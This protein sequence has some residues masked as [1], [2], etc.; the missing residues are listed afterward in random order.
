MITKKLALAVGAVI[1]LTACSDKASETKLQYP[2]TK[3]GEVVDSYFETKVADPYRW[4]EDDMSAETAAWVESQNQ[5]TQGYLEQIPYREQIEQRLTKL[6]DYK[7]EG[8]PFVEGDYRYYYKNDGL[9]NQSVLYRQRGDEAEEIFLDPNSFSEDGTVSLAGITFSED[10]SLAAYQISEGGSDWRKVYVIDTNTKQKLEA[11]LVD[12]KFSNISWRGNTGFYYSSYDKPKGSELSAKTD[13]HKLYFHKLGT[14]QNQDELVFGG[15]DSEKHRYVGSSVTKDEKYLFIYASVST[16][17]N[18]LFI[19][20]LTDA[21]KG[22]YTL[23]GDTSSDTELVT[24]KGEDF[25]LLTNKEAPNQRLVKVNLNALDTWVDIIA[26]REQV[27]DISK[28]GDTVFA[29]YLMDAATKVE[30]YDLAGNKVR[31]ISLPAIGT[32]SGFSGKESQAQVY[33]SFSNYHTPSS[34]YSYDLASGESS[35]YRQSNIEFDGSK[36]ESKQVFYASKDGT[37]V[38]MTIT[39][40]KGIELDGANPTLLYGYGGFNISLRPGFSTTRALWLELGGVYAVA[41][42][43][44]GG[45]YGKAWHKAG[46]QMQKQN[47][48]DDFIA[49]AEYLIENKYTS[50]SKLAIQGGSNGGLLVGATMLQRP[51]L[52]KVALPAVGVLDMLRYHTFTA[53]AGWAYDY[54]T[55]ND[56]QEMFDYLK[57]YS[58]V[59]NVKAGVDYPA[60]LITTGDHDD[61]VV[62]AHSYKFAAELQKLHTGSNPTLIRIETDAGHG[63]GTPTS[64]VIEQYADIYGFALYNMGVKKL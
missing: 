13:Q 29:K 49:A 45:E 33:Y 17:G 5:V 62:P 4:L 36:Y 25:Y 9:Q 3:Q 48:F 57:G 50:S 40:K 53:G 55:A 52:F 19:K 2:V 7:K 12:V 35:L 38:P 23:V 54:G 14:E 8:I 18:K 44:G 24:S 51:E 42:L 63:A 11:P 60:T 26:E 20:D 64:K 31:D 37:K 1:A 16:S 41:N 30:Q 61:R 6:M 34:I 39:Y 27:L 43:R 47:V 22:L 10:G 15:T 32:A 46:T 58:P 56:S 28:A 21:S 59:H